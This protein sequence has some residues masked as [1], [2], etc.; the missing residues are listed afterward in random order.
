MPGTFLPGPL[1][2]QRKLPLQLPQG[3][4]KLSDG[5]DQKN[6]KTKLTDSL[7]VSTEELLLPHSSEMRKSSDTPV[8]AGRIQHFIKEW[9]GL[10]QG[11][12]ILS[13]VT[14]YEIEF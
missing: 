1:S 11:S 10:T 2:I 9:R 13:A 14:G 8:V 7:N 6:N 4:K 12:S 3:R 5:T